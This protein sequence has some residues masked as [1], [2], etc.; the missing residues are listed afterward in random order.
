MSIR[1]RV[2][3][4]FVDPSDGLAITAT[5]GSGFRLQFDTASTAEGGI[6]P[7]PTESLLAALAACTAM[8]VASIL[9]KKRQPFDS[10]RI[11]VTGERAEEHPRVFTAITVEHQL[12]GSMTAE[13]VR[14]SV[15]LSATSYCPVSAMLSAAV[16]IEHRYRIRRDEAGEEESAL[17][18][19]TGPA[20]AR[21]AQDA[22]TG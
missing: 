10:Y 17:V 8:D 2:T 12:T 16:R 3:A 9:R 19:V 7:S 13:A 20:E 14:R 15:E 1:N 11:E 5:S 6:G 22:A 18:V 21:A 4:D